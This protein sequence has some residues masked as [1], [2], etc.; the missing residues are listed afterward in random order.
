LRSRAFTVRLAAVSFAVLMT[1]GLARA[2][3]VFVTY[4]TSDPGNHLVEEYISSGI[5]GVNTDAGIFT[6]D[7]DTPSG[8]AL[9]S[10]GDLY[11]A[12]FNTGTVT[13]FSPSG[14]N[15]GVVASGLTQPTGLAFDSFGNLY[16]A[17]NDNNGTVTEVPAGGGTPTAIATGLSDPTGLAV[18]SGTLYVS[19]Y[20][21][22]E[23]DEVPLGGSGLRSFTPFV[24]HDGGFDD[25]NKPV[26][27][28]F[29][30]SGNLYVANSGINSIE[31][32]TPDGTG[33]VFASNPDTT[34]NPSGLNDPMGLAFDS[35]GDLF[36][37]NYHHD[38]PEH[39]G[40]STIEEFSSSGN[41][42]D[43]FDV[44]DLRDADFIAIEVPE[45]AIAGFL[46]LGAATFFG[47]SRLRRLR[48]A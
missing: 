30:A 11:L 38:G 15:L 13:E 39:T 40:T 16:I 20:V 45:P 26:G 21:N 37:A 44:P 32:F 12:D 34:D 31:Q 7:A 4:S 43:T 41:L 22:S 25:L 28:A 23:I 2:D 19:S 24:T 42:L 10:S 1:A 14:A 8:I 46:A 29:D 18:L 3:Q 6:T 5:T 48:G 17:S 35:S 36:V 33:S 9:D 27:L 47:V